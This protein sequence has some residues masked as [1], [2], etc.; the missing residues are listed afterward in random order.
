MFK[1]IT[2]MMLLLVIG[3]QITLSNNYTDYK[4]LR[5]REYGSIIVIEDTLWEKWPYKYRNVLIFNESDYL[6]NYSISCYRELEKILKEM[7]IDL[8]NIVQNNI[9]YANIIQE[10]RNLLNNYG[11]KEVSITGFNNVIKI[12]LRR[13]NNI[14]QGLINE[15]RNILNENE[16]KN[17]RIIIR[18]LPFDSYSSGLFAVKLYSAIRIVRSKYEKE[19]GDAKLIMGMFETATVIVRGTPR[20]SIK[21]LIDFIRE[22]LNDTKT[23]FIVMLRDVEW[24]KIFSDFT[25]NPMVD[26]IDNTI[27]SNVSNNVVEMNNLDNFNNQFKSQNIF[28]VTLALI[29]LLVIIISLIL[30]TIRRFKLSK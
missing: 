2:C 9:I 6:V 27:T 7:N 29:P 26:D 5:V 16:Y 30:N 3:F 1:I 4:W 11:F 24:E 25:S 13:D 8:G 15:I 21:K 23:P 10:I 18:V 17:L 22:E 28:V 19:L 12:V 20:V 14:T